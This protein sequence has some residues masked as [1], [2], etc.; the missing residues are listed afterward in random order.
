MSNILRTTIALDELLEL[1]S[2]VYPQPYNWDNT[3][4]YM[5]SEPLDWQIVEELVRVLDSGDKFREPVYVG[6]DTAWEDNE[7]YVPNKPHVGDGTHR[8][9]AHIIYGSKMVDVEFEDLED[10]DRDGEAEDTVELENED[11]E[12]YRFLTTTI[13]FPEPL[14]ESIEEEDL[15][16]STVRSFKVNDKLWL[17]SDM[18]SG[19]RDTEFVIN[20]NCEEDIDSVELQDTI[21]RICLERI[22]TFMGVE[23][24]S[25]VTAVE[26]WTND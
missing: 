11:P 17:V 4:A 15:M 14:G 20:W 7:Y 16:F 6:Y 19:T 3:V 26:E 5:K 25:V 22:R 8:V 1:T 12:T 23:P 21:T 24:K 18:M 10:F 2:P 9:V 13:I